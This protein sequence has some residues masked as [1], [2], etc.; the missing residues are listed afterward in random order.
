M[1]CRYP[2][3]NHS[4][5]RAPAVAAL[6]GYADF[7]ARFLRRAAASSEAAQA[8]PYSTGQI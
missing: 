1:S 7:G 4:S 2:F 3:R 5:G 6:R 8:Y